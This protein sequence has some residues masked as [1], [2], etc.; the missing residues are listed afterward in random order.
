MRKAGRKSRKSHKSRKSSEP[1]TKSV[2][3][4]SRPVNRKATHAT[5]AM[6]VTQLHFMARSLGI[7]FGGLAKQQLIKE[8]NRY[9]I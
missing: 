2:K 5:S 4:L 1:K 3:S 9:M 7:A 6:T 8:I